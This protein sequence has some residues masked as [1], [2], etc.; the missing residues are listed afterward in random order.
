MRN[1]LT[2]ETVKR[3]SSYPFQHKKHAEVFS[4][5]LNLLEDCV[6]EPEKEKSQKMIEEVLRI[7]QA[8]LQSCPPGLREP[9][10]VR[11]KGRI[12]VAEQK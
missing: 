1:A 10:H 12:W 9:F 4:G 8:S 3:V 2:R 11:L 6:E 5:L 7:I